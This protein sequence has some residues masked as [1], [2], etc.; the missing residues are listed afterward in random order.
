MKISLWAEIHRLRDRYGLSQRA[1]ADQLHCSRDTVK[2]AL[3]FVEAPPPA[4]SI[5]GSM[6][7]PYKAKIDALIAKY[8]ALSAIRVRE[9]IAKAGYD[10]ELTLVRDYLRVIRPARGR[11]YQEVDYPPG[12]AMQIDWGSCGVVPVGESL[13]KVSVFVAVLCFSRL[14][15][16]EFSL[17]QTKAHFYRCFTNSLRFFGGAVEIVIIDNFRTA[18]AEGSGRNARFQAEFAEF[19]GYHRLKPL[20]C[21]RSDP[22]SKGVVEDGVRY[23]KHNA[24]K[25]RDEELTSVD[26]YDHLAVYWRDSIANVRVHETTGERPIDRF[27]KERA[28][29]QLLPTH[30]YDTDDVIPTVVTPHARVRFETNRYSVPPAYTRKTVI[31]RVDNEWLRVC[32]AGTE[33]ARH[34]RSFERKRLITDPAHQVAALAL[35]KRSEV[36]LIEA[37]FDALGPCAKTFRE[38]LLNT[39]VKSV[40]H[41]RRILG[42]VRLYGKA[43]VIAAIQRALDLSTFD[44]AYVVNLI[45]QERRKRQIPSPIAI[46]PSRR[47]LIEEFDLD[48]PDPGI[49][50][51]LLH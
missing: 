38:K 17:S 4:T 37:Q 3:D 19:C 35:R 24:L 47:E 14:I 15:Y 45:D 13:R 50:E 48:V 23:V 49:Y 21:E 5:R 44:S 36:R 51:N 33:I 25:G 26:A 20:A 6:L 32:H 9:E 18:V 31:V 12:R 46:A 42:L 40:I 16:I 28:L 29:L 2:E 41:L 30:P 11:V 7:D 39:P 10:G 27:E 1:I 34:R 8:P 22:E 43:E